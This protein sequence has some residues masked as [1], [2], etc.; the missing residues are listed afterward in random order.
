MTAVDGVIWEG[1]D[2]AGTVTSK[3]TVDDFQA[4]FDHQS[5]PSAPQPDFRSGL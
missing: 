1:L 5:D 4:A 3:S 2:D